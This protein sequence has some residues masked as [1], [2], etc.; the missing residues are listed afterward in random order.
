[1]S[2][3]LPFTPQLLPGTAPAA[4]AA[5]SPGKATPAAAAA[6][7]FPMSAQ[8]AT[9][10]SFGAL[11]LTLLRASEGKAK[12]YRAML[13]AQALS[14][15]AGAHKCNTATRSLA[16]HAM[17]YSDNRNKPAGAMLGPARCCMV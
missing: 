13:A 17:M 15:L 3:L 1:M 11:E 4:T 7:P 9:A 16:C 2:I 5:T 8:A 14:R 12:N 6:Q 10:H